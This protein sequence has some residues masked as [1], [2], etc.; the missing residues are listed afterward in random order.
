[1]A[2]RNITREL[3]DTGRDPHVPERGVRQNQCSRGDWRHHSPLY[4]CRWVYPTA[5]TPLSNTY[6]FQLVAGDWLISSRL[7]NSWSYLLGS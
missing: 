4:P 7:I 6:G 3:A 5:E 1:M 2:W